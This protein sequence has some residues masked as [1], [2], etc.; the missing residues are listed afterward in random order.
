VSQG[1]AK[2]S[3]SDHSK[4]QRCLTDVL[5]TT[6]LARKGGSVMKILI[7]ALIALSVL[8]GVAAPA[9]ALDTRKFFDQIDRESY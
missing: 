4:A 3:S 7:S 5:S 8:V 1:T 2:E 6:S 9:S